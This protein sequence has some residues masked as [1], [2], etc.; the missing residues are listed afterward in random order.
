MKDGGYKNRQKS[1]G[2]SKYYRFFTPRNKEFPQQLELFSRKPDVL[3]LAED[4]NL[5]PIPVDEDLSS[6]SAI[7]MNDDYYHF[8]I[9]NS[10]EENGLHLAGIETLIC[11]KAKA[12]LDLRSRKEKGKQIDEHNIRKHK[13]DIIRL[14][15]MLTGESSIK[16]PSSIEADIREF[17]ESINSDSPDYKSIG[18]NAGVPDI[19]GD[20][21]IE[22]LINTFSL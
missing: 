21:I 12:F 10:H 19:D 22:Q 13:N 14:A 18:K 2:E 3:V 8:T 11:L 4:S 7:L 20:K 15:I 6:L 5:T 17:I 16:L 9:E 1:T